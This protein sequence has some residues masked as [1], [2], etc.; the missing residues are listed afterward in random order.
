MGCGKMYEIGNLVMYGIHGVCR[1][2]EEEERKVDRK[3]VQY[4]VLE[5]LEQPGT[6]FLVPAH[7][8]AALAKLHSVLTR[9]ELEQMLRSEQ[10]RENVWIEDSNQRKQCY[11]ELISSGD[12]VAL[13]QMIRALQKHRQAQLDAGRKF[14]LADENFLRDAMRLLSS[15][16]ALVL[17]ID[18]KDVKDYVLSR[19]EE[20]K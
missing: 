7:N 13:L 16:F 5:P 19:L 20:N 11:R 2:I 10:V 17:G 8:Q 4:L 12:R 15:E 1:I 14:H 9:D 18:A 6:R 3:L